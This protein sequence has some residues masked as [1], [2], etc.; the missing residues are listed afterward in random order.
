MMA[1]GGIPCGN[2]VGATLTPLAGGVAGAGAGAAAVGE[3]EGDDPDE[4]G[5]EL[6]GA[7][8]AAG[9]L[10]EGA[11]TEAMEG[12]ELDGAGEPLELPLE[13]VEP[14]AGAGAGVGLFEPFT[15][16]EPSW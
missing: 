11:G 10:L 2:D 7:A 1:C 4:P 13:G 15:F 5:F 6:V 8:L 16:R 14:A 12:P 3:L 9:P